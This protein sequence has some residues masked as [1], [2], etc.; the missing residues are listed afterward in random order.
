MSKYKASPSRFP[1]RPPLSVNLPELKDGEWEWEVEKV[2]D[3]KVDRR[4]VTKFLVY[5]IG[6]PKPEWKPLEELKHCK[7]VL[8][9]YF[10][11]TGEE[12]PSNVQSFLD[13]DS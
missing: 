4:G 13:E 6:Y 7:E 9:D 11:R 1:N 3:M 5:W 12:I 10:E 2:D 8:K